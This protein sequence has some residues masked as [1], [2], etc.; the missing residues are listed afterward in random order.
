MRSQKHGQNAVGR[1]IREFRIKNGE[2]QQELGEIIGYSATTVANYE[3][4]YRL[5]D[6]ITARTIAEH[7]GVSIEALFKQE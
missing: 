2:T 5:P 3:S 7:Y 4:G 6:V 1:N